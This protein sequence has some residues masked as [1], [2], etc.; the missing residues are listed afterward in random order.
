MEKINEIRNYV[1]KEISRNELISKKHKKVCR[2]KKSAIE[3]GTKV[4]L[5]L[6]ANII[7]DSNDE[8]NF[9]HKGLLLDTHIS[10]PFKAF[11]DG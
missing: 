5:N 11:S 3:N 1:I 8:N 7:S 10:K 4:A 2:Q 6:S 9:L